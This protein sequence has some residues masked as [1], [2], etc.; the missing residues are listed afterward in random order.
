LP[1]PQLEIS[2]AQQQTHVVVL[3]RVCVLCAR[4]TAIKNAL[5]RL[6]AVTGD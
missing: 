1:L 6:I 4:A 2:V 5:R 3:Q